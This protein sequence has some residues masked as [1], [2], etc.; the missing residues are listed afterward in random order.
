M[1]KKKIIIIS[2]SVILIIA[3]FLLVL[4]MLNNLNNKTNKVYGTVINEFDNIYKLKTDN[5]EVVFES[6]DKLDVGDFVVLI[7]K[8]NQKN[9]EEVEV[10]MDN[11][12]VIDE[13]IVKNDETTTIISTTKNKTTTNNK[14]N[15]T[16]TTIKSTT[17]VNSKKVNV[18]SD[19]KSS[20]DNLNVSEKSKEKFIELVD[21]IFY[22][23]EINGV[24][25]DSLKNNVKLKII[26]Y[27]LLIDNKIEQKYPNYKEK[28][29]LKYQNA[30]YKLIASYLDFSTNVCKNS[31]DNCKQVKSDFN[32]LK[33]SFSLTWDL[34]KNCFEYASNKTTTT[35][36]NWYEI[37]RGQ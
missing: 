37:Y 16:S 1:N 8:N 33:Q 18:L 20:Y 12:K 13:K 5:S 32:D 9:P 31:K 27:T 14:K 4:L 26:Y 19:I 11:I 10:L 34:I 28:L 6:K 24:T 36:K 35:L 29:N 21:F 2:T 15:N 17:V 25:F 22:G 30:K 23:K 7:Y 3:I